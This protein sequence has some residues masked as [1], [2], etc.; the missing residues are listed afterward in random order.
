MNSLGYE[1]GFLKTAKKEFLTWEGIHNASYEEITGQYIKSIITL[2]VC[3]GIKLV[4]LLNLLTKTFKSLRKSVILVGAYFPL[5]NTIKLDFRKSQDTV[6][7][8]LKTKGKDNRSKNR[9]LE[10]C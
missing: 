7:I 8:A 4:C 3:I 1:K 2:I 5:P 10:R 9:S 6:F